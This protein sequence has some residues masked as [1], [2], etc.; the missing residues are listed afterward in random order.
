MPGGCPAP[1]AVSE[2]TLNSPTMGRLLPGYRSL[3]GSSAGQ[4]IAGGARSAL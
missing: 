4:S 1:Q 2:E 3:F